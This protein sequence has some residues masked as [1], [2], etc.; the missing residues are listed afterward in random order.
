MFEKAIIQWYSDNKR[1]LPWR[2]TK[3]PYRIW[4]SEIILQQT[5]IAQGYDYYVRFLERFPD[6][7]SLAEAPEDEV[8]KMWQDWDII[9]GQETST[10]PRNKSFRP[11]DSP[12]TMKKCENSKGLETIRLLP[13]VPLPTDSLMQWLTA[14]Y[15]GSSHAIWA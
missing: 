6:V 2:D 3:D 15:I 8:M 7:K 11:G 14:M 1:E 12:K 13:F 9:P 10:K 4:I 5:R